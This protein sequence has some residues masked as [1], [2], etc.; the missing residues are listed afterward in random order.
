MFIPQS[1]EVSVFTFQIAP[2]K[3][4]GDLKIFIKAAAGLSDRQQQ[5]A[6]IIVFQGQLPVAMEFI[7][8]MVFSV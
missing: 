6:S 3:R 7:K 5:Y 2:L 8:S 1:H 4:R